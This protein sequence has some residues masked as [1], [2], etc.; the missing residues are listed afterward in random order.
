V[1]KRPDL[2]IEGPIQYDAADMEV[3]QSKMP[4]QLWTGK[5]AFLI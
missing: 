3:G 2:K 4:I 5:C 1:R